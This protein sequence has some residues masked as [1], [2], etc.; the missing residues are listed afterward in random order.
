M[1]GFDAA[2]MEGRA[3]LIPVSDVDRTPYVG[4]VHSVRDELKNAPEAEETDPIDDSQQE[5]E[6]DNRNY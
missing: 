1:E 3:E 4:L 6:Q 5:H 2:I